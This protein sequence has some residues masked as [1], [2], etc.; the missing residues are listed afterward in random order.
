MR[1][2]GSGGVTLE[3]HTR[4]FGNRNVGM[5]NLS[6]LQVAGMLTF[7]PAV[8][9][10]WWATVPLENDLAGPLEELLANAV[11]TFSVC[12]VPLAQSHLV[13]LYVAPE[14]LG[15]ISVPERHHVSLSIDFYTDALRKWRTKVDRS[16][17]AGDR[18]PLRLWM[19]IEGWEFRSVV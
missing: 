4:L 14:P 16:N 3:S 11:A 10:G 18:E 2:D 8:C 13:D 5:L 19:H 7:G 9:T 1:I 17:R 15:E 6:N 12:D